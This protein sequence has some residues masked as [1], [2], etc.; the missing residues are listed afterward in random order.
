MRRTVGRRRKRGTGYDAG[1]S[2]WTFRIVTAISLALCIAACVSWNW[3]YGVEERWSCEGT[4]RHWA[5]SAWK[6]RLD[7]VLCKRGTPSRVNAGLTH[8]STTPLPPIALAKLVAKWTAYDDYRKSLE[9]AVATG[10]ST[11]LMAQPTQYGWDN[12]GVWRWT[13]QTP[14]PP[15]Y[16]RVATPLGVLAFLSSLMPIAFV[17]LWVRRL[18]RC[19]AGRCIDCGYDLRATPD[20]CPE[21]GTAA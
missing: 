21:C 3:S 10:K 5:V 18:R 20:R 17:A 7:F 9:N 15:S 1:V 13:G 16:I 4:G 2:R 6:G 12:F 14:S 19:D 8:R 11:P